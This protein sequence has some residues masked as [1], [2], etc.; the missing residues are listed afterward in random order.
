MKILFVRPNPS[1]ETIGLQHIMR[2]EP[3]ELEI[4]ATIVKDKNDVKI[5]DMILEKKSIQYFIDK[6]EPDMFCVTGYITH[7]PIMINYCRIAK[8]S[9][10]KIITVVGGVYIEKFPEDIESMYVDYRV[11]RNATRNF[12]LLV[13]FLI[14]KSVFP[15]GVLKKGES[16]NEAFLPKYDFFYPVPDRTLTQKYRKNYFYVFHN[17]VALIKTS[18]GCPYNCNFCFC[19]KITDG[20][21]F[22]RPL[23]EV[24]EEL[25][26]IKEREIYIVD[27]NFLLSG[28]RIRQFIR[29]LKERKIDKRYLVFG[30]ADFIADNP[31]IIRDFKE[32]GL[33]TVLV[34]LESF[35]NKELSGFVKQTNSNINQQAVRVLNKYKVYCFAAVI[36]S[37]SWD[38]NDFSHAGEILEELNIKFLNLQPLA[39]IKGTG[40]DIDDSSLVIDRKDF[41]RWDLAHVV[42]KPE[43]MSLNEYYKSIIGLY[44]RIIV[45]PRHLIGYIKYSPA[46]QF[47]MIKG[48]YKIFKQY[49]E[50]I[51]VVKD[52]AA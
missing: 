21:Y 11:V 48:I 39:P 44:L 2:V 30:R 33:R 24:V 5:I 35:I 23:E 34:G 17:K 51:S 27:D 9:N 20:K 6:Y 10:E 37:P 52:F 41:V 32:V 22:A 31:D 8:N 45:K 42:V 46:M 25:G 13:D 15:A 19:R 50:K 18:F 47:R 49:R 1:P 29:L 16:L 26:N 12:P 36:T 4:L 40:L 7:I 38:K 3:L 43:K 14:G 28:M